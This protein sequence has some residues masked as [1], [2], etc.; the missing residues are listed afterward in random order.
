MVGA[1]I[2][3]V[4]F[5]VGALFVTSLW[6]GPLFRGRYA[7]PEDRRRENRHKFRRRTRA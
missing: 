1:I 4:L 6:L 2:I 5:L 7:K 3:G